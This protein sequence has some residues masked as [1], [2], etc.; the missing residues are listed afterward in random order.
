[1]SDSDDYNN[2]VHITFLELT[3]DEK[4]V[5]SYVEKFAHVAYFCSDVS[6]ELRRRKLLRIGKEEW[7]RFEKAFQGPLENGE[8]A[9]FCYSDKDRH[10]SQLDLYS[11][12]EDHSC[13]LSNK[14]SEFVFE[15]LCYNGK[16][17]NEDT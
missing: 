9:V 16:F 17:L 7:E 10:V 13:S 1:M 2:E 5:A 15:T 4:D 14:D 6:D 8:R 11:P 3:F 12:Y